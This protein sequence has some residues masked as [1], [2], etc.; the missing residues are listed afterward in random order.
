MERGAPPAA[1]VPSPVGREG[2]GGRP[3]L[4]LGS[5]SPRRR[6]LLAKIGVTPDEIRAADI[7][8]TPAKGE[9]PRA[10]VQRM[11]R[12]KGTA[13]A[14]GLPSP[15]EG[16]L[17][18]GGGPADDPLILTADTV[19]S[20]GRRILGKPADAAE[21]AAFL[22]LLS[23]RRHRVTTAVCLARGA[24]IRTRTVETRVRFKRLS[25]REI[26]DYLASGEWRGKAGGYAIQG[27]A[28]AFVPSINGSY[29]NVVG[30]PLTETAALLAGMG[31]PISYRG[32]P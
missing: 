16:G 25:E 9:L 6:D 23:G 29:S 26:A 18:R 19:V 20:A 5:A 7:D 11:A 4:I 30:L 13:L 27:L 3:H 15:L 2:E 21:A 24:T 12:E 8:E 32:A 1:G 17:G 28:G 31:Y 10:F 22:R 14:A